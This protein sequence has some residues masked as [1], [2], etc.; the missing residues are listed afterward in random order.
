MTYSTRNCSGA[1]VLAACWLVWTCHAALLACF[2]D[3]PQETEKEYRRDV[4]ALEA[5]NLKFSLDG[6]EL[7]ATLVEEPVLRWANNVRGGPGGGTYLW[8]AKG[9]PVAMCCIWWS[10]KQQVHLAFHSLTEQPISAEKAGR[11]VWHTA[12]PG[13]EY[14]DVP[15]APAAAHSAAARLTQL[16]NIAR[17]FNAALIFG[18]KTEEL[19]LLPQPLYRYPGDDSTIKDGGVFAFVT[20]TDPELILQIEAV[21]SGPEGLRWRY[22]V[23]RRTAVALRVSHKDQVVWTCESTEGAADEPFFIRPAR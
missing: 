10:N 18:Q 9:L 8:T 6:D 3:E 22:A 1:I 20:G 4:V 7:C 17:E 2:A 23:T 14:R 19:R 5:R 15:G 11:V 13:V 16:R 12:K 21:G